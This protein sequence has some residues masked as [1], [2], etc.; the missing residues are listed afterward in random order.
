MTLTATAPPAIIADICE[1]LSLSNVTTIYIS[2]FAHTPYKV[3][4]R[5]CY[6]IQT[7]YIKYNNTIKIYK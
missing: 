6:C 7:E 5:K 1:V 2:L 4:H 3:V